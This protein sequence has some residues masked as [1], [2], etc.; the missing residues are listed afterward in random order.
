MSAPNASKSSNSTSNDIVDERLK[1]AVE[2]CC[3]TLI[4]DRARSNYVKPTRLRQMDPMEECF[5]GTM[6][7]RIKCRR[8]RYALEALDYAEDWGEQTFLLNP[9]KFP[10]N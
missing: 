1:N 7:N 9:D 2:E 6:A 3:K 5:D 8:I 4:N 10:D